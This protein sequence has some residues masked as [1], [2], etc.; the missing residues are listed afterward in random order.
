MIQVILFSTLNNLLKKKQNNVK[1]LLMIQ[2]IKKTMEKSD[3]V[4]PNLLKFLK[5][6][7]LKFLKIMF[8]KPY[9]IKKLNLMLDDELILKT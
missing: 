4:K 8:E 5:N 7:M 1:I 2:H 3:P 9:L 6:L